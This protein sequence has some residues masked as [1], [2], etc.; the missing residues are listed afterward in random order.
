M[1]ADLRFFDYPSADADTTGDLSDEEIVQLV[2][3]EQNVSE[4]ADD[5]ETAPVPSLGHVMDATNLLSRF[6]GAHEG[7]P[8]GALNALACYQRYEAKPGEN[9]RV[10]CQDINSFSPEPL[11]F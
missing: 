6:S 4:H 3:G 2:S 8:E 11:A 9:R 1:A 5:P 7:T 10:S